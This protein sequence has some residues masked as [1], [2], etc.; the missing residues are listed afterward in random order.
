VTHIY[1]AWTR[2]LFCIICNGYTYTHNI[3]AFTAA[4]AVALLLLIGCTYFRRLSLV[5]GRERA[6]TH[7]HTLHIS[8][9]NNNIYVYT[10]SVWLSR[11]R[12]EVSAC[13][14]EPVVT[15]RMH[16]GRVTSI[17]NNNNNNH[18][19]IWQDDLSRSLL[20]VRLTLKECA[21]CARR[22][23]R[24]LA[25]VQAAA[26]RYTYYIYVHILLLYHI[27]IIHIKTRTHTHTHEHIHIYIL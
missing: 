3:Y 14:G 11:L 19:K 24:P 5:S 12:G 18:T 13:R 27:I 23:R 25:A 1:I 21:E 8:I 15:D 2:E 6:H 16:A 4:A 17:E 10:Y 9:I 22:Y 26:Q 7:T 20:G